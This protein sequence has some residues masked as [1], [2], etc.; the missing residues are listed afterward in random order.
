MNKISIVCFA[1]MSVCTVR[2]Q[3][4]TG[5]IPEGLTDWIRIERD[6]VNL[7]KGPSAST[8]RLMYEPYPDTDGSTVFWGQKETA[9]VYPVQAENGE[10][11]PLIDRNHNYNPRYDDIP[12]DAELWVK[13]GYNFQSEEYPVW[14][15]QEFTTRM[16]VSPLKANNYKRNG[17]PADFLYIRKGGKYDGLCLFDA[18]PMHTPEDPEGLFVGKLDETEG[19]AVLPLRYSGYLVNQGA[20]IDRFIVSEGYIA[21]PEKYEIGVDNGLRGALIPD[22]SK[23]TDD[24]IARIIA[25]CEPQSEEILLFDN[26][27]IDPFEGGG[28]MQF[29]IY[30]EPDNNGKRT[31]CDFPLK[32][33][34][35]KI[36]NEKTADRRAPVKETIEA[37]NYIYAGEESRPSRSGNSGFS[38]DDILPDSPGNNKIYDTVDVAPSFPGGLGA[39]ISWLGKNMKYPENAQYRNIQGR[40]LVRFVVLSDGSIGKAQVANGVEQSLDA[41][42][43]RLI[44]GMPK[45]NPGT[46]NGKPV[47]SWFSLPV[48]FKLNQ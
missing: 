42:A 11:L 27:F 17:V 1:L 26:P 22:Y 14:V 44:K 38:M 24:D 20:E 45:W 33:V 10:I 4:I 29:N 40:V 8:P 35:L 47:N 39:V 41:E 16:P 6:N 13:V 31:W 23:L 25:Q 18:D 5:Y 36:S 32:K 7:R 9:N 46:I 37:D 3:E 48:T 12:E 19:I 43:L 34:T 30:T 2:A 15:K 28:Y 21:Y